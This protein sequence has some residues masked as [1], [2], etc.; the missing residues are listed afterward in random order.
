LFST[1]HCRYEREV[2]HLKRDKLITNSHSLTELTG[3][4]QHVSLQRLTFPLYVPELPPHSTVNS[5]KT[6]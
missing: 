3:A 5:E 6:T 1:Q 2:T 4:E